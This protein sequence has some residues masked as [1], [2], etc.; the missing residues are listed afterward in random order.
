MDLAEAITITKFYPDWITSL[1]GKRKAWA[2]RELKR[3]NR[4]VGDQ[5]GPVRLAA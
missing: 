2:K 3:A 4:I 1:Q 5:P